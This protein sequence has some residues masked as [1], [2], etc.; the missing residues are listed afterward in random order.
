MNSLLVDLYTPKSNIRTKYLVIKFINWVKTFDSD[1]HSYIRYFDLLLRWTFLLSL[2]LPSRSHPER[3]LWMRGDW[4]RL[5]SVAYSYCWCECALNGLRAN[6][7]LLES[8]S[9]W[10]RCALKG[11]IGESDTLLETFL[12]D[13]DVLWMGCRQ[14]RY[15]LRM[16]EWWIRYS[17]KTSKWLGLMCSECVNGTA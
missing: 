8:F 9:V 1:P 5:L 16:N 13:I 7:I 11:V 17:L 2:L 14:I 12:I 15:T 3:S 10:Y 4:L 6:Q